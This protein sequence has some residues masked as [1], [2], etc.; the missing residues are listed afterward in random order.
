MIDGYLYTGQEC[1]CPDHVLG[2]NPSTWAARDIWSTPLPQCQKRST[3]L[4]LRALTLLA[5]RYVI[6]IEGRLDLLGPASDPFILVIN[7]NQRLES[8]L[9]PALLFFQRGGKTIHFLA[10]WPMLLMPVVASMY[11]RSEAII[12]TSKSSRPKFLNVFKPMFVQAEPAFER[13][14]HCLSAGA[15]VGLF[16]EGTMNRDP[17]RLMFGRS[18]AARLALTSGVKVIPLGIR[19]PELDRDQI[20][21]D[22]ARMSLHVGE[23]LLPPTPLA[24]PTDLDTSAFHQAMME[25]LAQVCGKTWQVAANKRRRYVG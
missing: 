20:I 16:P 3:R 15:S 21:P 11:R 10:D 25:R 6:S 8:V 9:V 5:R 23:P 14:L 22:G 4:L 2:P 17:N 12:V 1:A 7:H 13:A 19:F 24:E 18:G